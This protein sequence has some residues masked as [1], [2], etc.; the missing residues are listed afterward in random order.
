MIDNTTWSPRRIYL[1]LVCLVTLV[2]VL[3]ACAVPTPTPDAVATQVALALAVEGTMTALAP[4]LTPTPSVTLTPEESSTLTSTATA[5]NTATPTSTPSGTPTWTPL[6]SATPTDTPIP[7]PE[8]PEGW[9]K[10]TEIT[11]EF[12]FWAPPMLRVSSERG[13]HISLS[14]DRLTLDVSLQKSELCGPYAIT[15][16]EA[17]I[18]C[19]VRGLSEATTGGGFRFILHSK[20]VHEIGLY[21]GY[22]FEYSVTRYVTF[23]L[24]QFI[25]LDSE[26]G[27]L[28]SVLYGTS[29]GQGFTHTEED[30]FEAI[31]NSLR[32]H[33]PGVPMRKESM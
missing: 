31:V 10:H 1:Y 13:G 23:R 14:G 19:F 26:S 22:L 30:L 20:G 17:F 28:L 7:T 33:S 2:T 29:R 6:P 27:K 24:K 12:T 3:T 15:A 18:N 11:D 5:T 4:T 16:D 25:V 32:I 8:V 21:R 9:G